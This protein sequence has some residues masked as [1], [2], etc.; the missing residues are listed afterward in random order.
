MH[1]SRPL[2]AAILLRL[3][4]PA[5]LLL[6]GETAGAQPAVGPAAFAPAPE[7][8][9]RH[10]AYEQHALTHA[11]DASRGRRLFDETERTRCKVCHQIDG[12]GGQVG[13]ELTSIGGKFDRPH[14]I[15]SLLE[16]SRQIVEGF[17]TTVVVTKGGGV[18]TGVA[19]ARDERQLTLLDAGGREHVLERGEIEELSE[20]SASLMPQD[21][22]EQLSLE[23]FTDLIAYLESLRPGGKESHGGGLVGPV[24]LPQGFEVRVIATSLDAATAL[25][26]LPD[27]RVLVCEQTG[28]VRVIEQD[29]LLPEPFVTLPVDSR[30]ERGVIG[31]TIDPAFPREPYVYVCWVA[32]EPY[33]HHRVNRFTASGNV[34]AAG[35]ERVLLAGDDQRKLGGTVPAG[36]QGGAL[37]FGAGGKLYIGIGEQT[38]GEPAQ[39]LD[40]LLGKLLRIDSD[41]SIPPDNPFIAET[42]GKYQAIW[43]LGLRNPFTFAFSPLDGTLLINDVGGNF[44]EIN[45][46]RAGGN[47]GWPAVEHG[48]LGDGPYIGPIHWYP[49]ASI[50]GGAFPPLD[51][52]WPAAYRGRYF[53]ADFVHGWI[54]TLD[55]KQPQIAFTFATG[56]RRPVDLRFAPNGSLYVLVR[57]AWVIDERF[58]GGT[59]SLVEIRYAGAPA[60][61]PARAPE[62]PERVEGSVKLAPEAIDASA[63]GLPAYR[64]ETPAAVW[65]LEKTG[66]GLSS[67]IDADG[68]D[69]LGF[70]PRPGSR[71]G[72]E[73]RGF[74]N[75]VHQEDGSYFHPRNAATDPAVTRIER[76]EPHHVAIAVE[77]DR[78]HWACRYDFYPDRCDFTMTRAP[79]GR[80]FWVLY[81]GTPGGRFDATDWW[82]TSAIKERR[83]MEE[84]HE[85]DIPGP[86]WIAFGDAQLERAL[87]LI[88]HSDD[89]FPDTFY[90][91]DGQMTVFGFGRRGL[92]KYL[93]RIP[94]RVTIALLETTDHGEISRRVASILR[95]NQQE[96]EEGHGLRR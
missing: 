47:Y 34:A 42:R 69:W 86:E 94:T 43:A 81:E 38:A 75:A 71:A 49:Q 33:P 91:M 25:E 11:G 48:P 55:P 68:N 32:R 31:V 28:A 4:P 57:N 36:H 51:S 80:K 92:T 53:F 19:K 46:G 77:S 44:E 87:V 70:H 7:K 20:S 35:S 27:G 62:P 59:G 1:L 37:H 60:A 89:E 54:K 5:L 12:E 22:A 3:I 8:A 64:I 76:V 10:R 56:L 58:L 39:R 15:E 63:G 52:S 72:G 82:M 21:L 95:E 74:P 41:G 40:S 66:G 67:L 16:P 17:R 13:P 9:A 93:E 23:E 88:H 50:A 30:W 83:P 90:A 14:L 85:G 65:Y 96:E 73:F 78:G 6:S 18:L 24:R 79:E 26:T 45:L 84:R 29:R 2:A 61:P